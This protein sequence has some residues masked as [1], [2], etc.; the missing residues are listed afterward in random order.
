MLISLNWLNDYV[1]LS[2][3][4]PE[5][6]GELLSLHTAEVEGIEEVGASIADVVVGEVLERDQHPDADKLSVTTVSY[7]AE[8]NVGVVCGAPN[9]RAGLKIAFAP[10]G[11]KLPG[12]LKIKKAKLRGVV[13]CGMI[14]SERELEMS[15]EHGG[16]LELPEDA[17]VGVPLVEYLGLR[18]FVIELDNK[19]LTHRPDPVSYTHLTLP[20]KA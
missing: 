1:D 4:T 14:C 6:V 19:S 10:I 9:V 17:P 7:G 13:S 16:I 20:T 8:E 15:D 2:D 3:L 18:D 11:S 12:D 5:Q